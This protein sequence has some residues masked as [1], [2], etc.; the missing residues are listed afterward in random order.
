MDN[1]E[2][3]ANLTYNMQTAFDT[4]YDVLEAVKPDEVNSD[5]LL[6]LG[7]VTEHLN[8]HVVAYIDHAKDFLP[9]IEEA[10][11]EPS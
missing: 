2:K 11:D 7:S 3:L 10:I 1:T 4:F 6:D 8:T 5:L 9:T